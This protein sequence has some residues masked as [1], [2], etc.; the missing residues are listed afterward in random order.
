MAKYSYFVYS[1]DY[2]F[3]QVRKRGCYQGPLVIHMLAQ[4]LINTESA[5]TIPGLVDHND[6][7]KGA[8]A[9]SATAINSTIKII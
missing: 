5:I 6:F 4:H 2:F 8:L 9:L 1:T 7:P 3:I